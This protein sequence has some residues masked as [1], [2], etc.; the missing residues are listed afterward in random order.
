MTKSNNAIVSLVET[1]K[2]TSQGATV[3]TTSSK[4]S[5]TAVE[6]LNLIS[7]SAIACASGDK[8]KAEQAKQL[9]L[10]N[11]SA[12][13]LNQAGVRLLDGRKKDPSSMANRKAFLDQCEKSGLAPKTAQNYYELFFKVVNTGKPVKSF[14]FKTNAKKTGGDKTEPAIADVLAKFYN[15]SEF[16]SAPDEVQEWV[17][18]LL[19]S[20]NYL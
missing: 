15:H 13:N 12:I 14:D 10:F 9:D 17:T 2:T 7:A 11:K 19:V 8:A 18:E 3:K 6:T 16:E 20:A 5:L 4:P 1:V